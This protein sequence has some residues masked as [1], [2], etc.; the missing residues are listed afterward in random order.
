[1][2][3]SGIASEERWSGRKRSICAP[4]RADTHDL[5]S[6][7]RALEARPEAGTVTVFTPLD[8]RHHNIEF[9]PEP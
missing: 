5:T 7:S 4:R 6:G 3:P 1:M 9:E 8:E 2:R